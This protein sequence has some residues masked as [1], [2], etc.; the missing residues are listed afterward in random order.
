M[1]IIFTTPNVSDY[2]TFIL[3]HMNNRLRNST[4]KKQT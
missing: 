2:D 1:I 4:H 3:E